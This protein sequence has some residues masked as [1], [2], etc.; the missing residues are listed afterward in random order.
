MVTKG[1][2]VRAGV[3]QRLRARCNGRSSIRSW[4]ACSPLELGPPVGWPLKFRVSGPDA[5]K[6]RELRTGFALDCS[7]RHA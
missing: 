6:V 2:K 5:R 1:F 3:Q 7:A 4:R